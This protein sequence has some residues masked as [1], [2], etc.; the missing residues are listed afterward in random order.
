MEDIVVVR[1]EG[2]RQGRWYNEGNESFM[3]AV[4][5]SLVYKLFSSSQKHKKRR[6]SLPKLRTNV[7][8]EIQHIIEFSVHL[9]FFLPPSPP[10]QLIF[11]RQF[12]KRVV[13]FTSTNEQGSGTLPHPEHQTFFFPTNDLAF[14]SFTC[15]A[16]IFFF[17]LFFLYRERERGRG[18]AL[19][20]DS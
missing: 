5:L 1:R 9:R 20:K 13:G 16:F 18:R 4:W 10:L 15:S 7:Y 3:V 19:N 8:F 2:G 12:L 14:S 11:P 6:I 17:T